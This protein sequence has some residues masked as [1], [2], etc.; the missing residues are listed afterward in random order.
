MFDNFFKALYEK[1]KIVFLFKTSCFMMNL[2][3]VNIGGIGL[4]VWP[5]KN[6]S[7]SNCY[8]TFVQNLHDIGKFS[9]LH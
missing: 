6:I 9:P 2:K 4:G 7:L 1:T 5:L 3:E 8:L